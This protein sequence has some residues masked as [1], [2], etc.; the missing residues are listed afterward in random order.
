MIDRKIYPIFLKRKIFD[1]HNSLFFSFGIEGLSNVNFIFYYAWNTKSEM[2]PLCE[3][4]S[5]VYRIAQPN[6]YFSGSGEGC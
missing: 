3:H 6:M 4:T 2:L 1:A 5:G